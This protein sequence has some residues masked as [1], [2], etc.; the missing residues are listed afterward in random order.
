MW[1]KINN[2]T[3][4]I[5]SPGCLQSANRPEPFPGNPPP[6]R[7]CL[8]V[9]SQ[10]S[11]PSPLPARA[12]WDQEI[13]QE[14]SDHWS[15]AYVIKPSIHVDE[16][17]RLKCPV[18]HVEAIIRLDDWHWY[19]PKTS[20][21]CAST[22]CIVP[23]QRGGTGCMQRQAQQCDCTRGPLGGDASACGHPILAP[24]LGGDAS[25]GGHPLL[26]P[27][28]GGDASPGGH[29]LLAPPLRNSGDRVK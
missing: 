2:F 14:A 25:P 4:A 19:L 11:C 13:S 22:S 29:P 18:G 15:G 10:C 5:A 23:Q 8:P 16:K 21:P 12:A 28:L 27:H 7:R 3:S 24:P 9:G 17:Q 1:T 20:L 26:P 6:P